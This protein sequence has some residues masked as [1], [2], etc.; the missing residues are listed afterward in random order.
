M[1][2]CGATPEFTASDHYCTFHEGHVGQHYSGGVRWGQARPPGMVRD[3]S[4]VDE[5]GLQMPC[6]TCRLDKEA[7]GKSHGLPAAWRMPVRGRENGDGSSFV[8]WDLSPNTA[9]TITEHCADDFT[10]GVGVVGLDDTSHE[11]RLV[12]RNGLALFLFEL[13]ELIGEDVHELVAKYGASKPEP[14]K[15]QP[16]SWSAWNMKTVG[17]PPWVPPTDPAEADKH[18]V[19]VSWDDKP[20]PLFR[21]RFHDSQR[22]WAQDYGED[23]WTADRLRV[24]ARELVAETLRVAPVDCPPNVAVFY[25]Q[26][27][28]ERLTARGAA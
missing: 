23:K 14:P 8:R 27:A 6:G 5:C 7:N 25:D 13:T 22:Q 28:V 17:V 11:S 18:T 2:Q 19:T 24:K 10:V 1:S 12:T 16:A 4:S 9:L 26:A 20:E 15:P 3:Y 21:L